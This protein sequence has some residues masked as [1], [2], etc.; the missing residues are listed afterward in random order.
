MKVFGGIEAG[1]TKFVCVIG[2]GPDNI[3][4]EERFATDG[5]EDTIGRAIA[6]FQQYRHEHELNAIGIASFGP[7]DLDP[8]SQTY[9]YITTT[10]KPGWTH[11]DICGRIQRACHVPVAFDTDVNAAALGEHY[12]VAQNRTLDTL[13]YITV[14]TGIGMGG[15]MNGQPLHGLLHPEAGHV[16]IPHDRQVDPFPGCCPY[17]GD[18]LEGLAAGPALAMRWGM[19]GEL[20]PVNHPAWELEAHYLGLALCNLILALSPQRI[21]LGGGV[22]QQ[23]GLYPLVQSEVQHLLSGYLKTDQITQHIEHYIVAPALGNHSGVLG[24][25]ALAAVA[26]G[27]AVTA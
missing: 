4:A 6:F 12:W 26:E 19:R 5:P 8:A 13:L 11:T 9:G 7:L 14:G 3:L 2:T 24:A 20:L 21:V 27:Q 15:I 17:H 10:P 22:M 1:G 23:V 16:F 18:C 25:L